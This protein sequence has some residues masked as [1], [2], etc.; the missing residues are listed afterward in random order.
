MIWGQK[1]EK[2]HT[3]YRKFRPEGNRLGAVDAM[4]MGWTGHWPANRYPQIGPGRIKVRVEG[5]QRE[6]NRHVFTQGP[7]LRCTVNSSDP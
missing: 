4:T 3:W 1:Q 5:A 2:T 6:D 7:R